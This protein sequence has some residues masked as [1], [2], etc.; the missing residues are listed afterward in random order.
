[1]IGT[2]PLLFSLPEWLVKLVPAVLQIYWLGL[3][4]VKKIGGD[5]AVLYKTIFSFVG[6]AAATAYLIA[7]YLVKHIKRKSASWRM[8]FVVASLIIMAVLI[9]VFINVEWKDVKPKDMWDLL[10]AAA[11]MGYIMAISL[12]FPAHFI[13]E[14][15]LLKKP[16][17]K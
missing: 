12:V 1:L 10:I 9:N 17:S 14:L 16:S 3:A 4:L 5:N 15:L 6:S 7:R 11:W 2:A 8:Y 13:L